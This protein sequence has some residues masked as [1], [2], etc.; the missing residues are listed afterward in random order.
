[1][2]VLLKK[3]F[4]EQMSFFTFEFHGRITNI[5]FKDICIIESKGHNIIIKTKKGEYICRA[6]MKN[7]LETL[8]EKILFKSKKHMLLILTILKKLI[9]A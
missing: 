9:K 8:G 5:Y 6:S 4:N 7:I 3:Y 2:F 1:M